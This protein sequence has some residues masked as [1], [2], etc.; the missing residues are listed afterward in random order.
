MSAELE[1]PSSARG[2]GREELRPEPQRRR[3]WIPGGTDDACGAGDELGPVDC[4]QPFPLK[5]HLLLDVRLR[6]W[7]EQE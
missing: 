7:K 3:R 1:C 5:P 2:I 4:F 6:Q